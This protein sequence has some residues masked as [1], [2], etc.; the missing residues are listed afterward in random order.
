MCRQRPCGRGSGVF[1]NIHTRCLNVN[2]PR[3]CSP[4]PMNSLFEQS[5]VSSSLPAYSRSA[6]LDG[7]CFA[8]ERFRLWFETIRPLLTLI[9]YYCAATSIQGDGTANARV[10]NND[11]TKSTV[12]IDV[13]INTTVREDA[14]KILMVPKMAIKN[15]LMVCRFKLP[16]IPF[17]IKSKTFSVERFYLNNHSINPLEPAFRQFFDDAVKFIPLEVTHYVRRDLLS[18]RLLRTTANTLYFSAG[19]LPPSSIYRPMPRD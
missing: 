1:R 5:V 19:S 4:P 17:L 13:V 12:V 3:S 7:L 10:E 2:S 16:L 18:Y 15:A 6:S 11:W 9:A 8:K 14:L